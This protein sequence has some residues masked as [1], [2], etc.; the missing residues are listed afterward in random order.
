MVDLK[1]MPEQAGQG[2]RQAP[3][4][5]VVDRRLAFPQVVNDQGADRLAG[6]GIPVDQLLDAQLPWRLECRTVGGAAGGKIPSVCS[7]W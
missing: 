3:Q 5:C 6:D 4:R 7:S 2:T 1:I